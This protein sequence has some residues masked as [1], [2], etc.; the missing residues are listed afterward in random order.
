LSCDQAQAAFVLYYRENCHLCESMRLALLRLQRSL[1]FTWHEIDI[2]RD[3]ALI[4]RFDVL[5]PVLYYQ[6]REVCHHFIDEGAIRRAV[7]PT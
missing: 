2:D 3:T 6:D 1:D 4:R 5:V 7:E